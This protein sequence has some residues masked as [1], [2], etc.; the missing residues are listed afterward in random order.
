MS[1]EDGVCVICKEGATSKKRLV[2]NPVMTDEIL[3]HCQERVSLGLNEGELKY[4]RYHSECR[5]PIVNKNKIE[6]LRKRSRTESPV[7]APRGPG[8][9]QV[10]WDL[11]GQSGQRLIPRNKLCLFSNCDSVPRMTQSHCSVILTDSMGKTL[12]QIKQ[13]TQMTMLEFQ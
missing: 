4:V 12:L 6:R 1:E 2:N 8:R 10:L 13:K 5:K 9:L 11:F 7:C 3:Q